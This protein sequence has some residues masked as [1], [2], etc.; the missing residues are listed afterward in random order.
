MNFLKIFEAVLGIGVQV[1]PI[2]IHNPQSQQVEAIIIT[3][4][5]AAMK[6]LNAAVTK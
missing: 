3:S 5:E 4:L 2:F 1:I 6:A